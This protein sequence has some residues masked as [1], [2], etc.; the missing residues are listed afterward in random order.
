MVTVRRTA[1]RRVS[2]NSAML[3]TG[4]PGDSSTFLRALSSNNSFAL[5]QPSS[6]SPAPPPAVAD[7]QS[8]SFD[9]YRVSE[10]QRFQQL[11][12]RDET[13]VLVLTEDGKLCYANPMARH[14]FQ[15][16]SSALVG[17][18]FLSL[19]HRGDLYRLMRAFEQL[20]GSESSTDC[21]VPS[22]PLRLFVRRDHWRWFKATATRLSYDAD[23][24]IIAFV[25]HPASEK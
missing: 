20:V 6:P 7:F 17:Q 3:P 12:C 1:K 18:H 14:T 9:L 19:A 15:T 23:Q 5:N 13:L 16:S 22:F 24:N 4:P 25:L 2:V 11:L 21:T 8:A 10:R